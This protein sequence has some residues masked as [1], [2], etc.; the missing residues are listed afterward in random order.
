VRA[1][2]ATTGVIFAALVVAHLWRVYL[3]GAH[4]AKDPWFI[5]FTILAAGFAAWAWRVLRAPSR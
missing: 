2:V 3:E 5:G 4:V 1:Y